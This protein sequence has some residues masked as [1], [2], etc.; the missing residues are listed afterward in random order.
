ME[1]KL[2][3][4]LFSENIYSYAILDGAAI[5][6]LLMK[7]FELRPPHVCL[8]RGE[9][10]ADL[11]EVAPYLVNLIPGTKFTS[12]LLSNCW[13]RHW[14]IFVH[15]PFP[16]VELRKHFRKF[17]TVH[18]EEGNPMLFRY[19]DPRVLP[20]FLPTCH[21]DELE[22]LFGKVKSYFA[23]SDDG[24]DLIRFQF[25]DK[26]LKQLNL[27]MEKS[28]AFPMMPPPPAAASAGEFQGNQFSEH[29]YA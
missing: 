8:Y 16:N 14:G 4:I 3:K 17:L 25:L 19:Y 11:A 7:L 26:K 9:L 1:R 6:D 15:S 10:E 28:N 23:E 13:G 12:W 29:R 22:L 20:K 24:R 2:E 18:S 27:S 5:P 21:E